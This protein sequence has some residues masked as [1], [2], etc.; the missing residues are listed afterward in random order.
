[1]PSRGHGWGHGFAS[2]P[3]GPAVRASAG[4][5]DHPTSTSRLLAPLRSSLRK[6]NL[7]VVRGGAPPE[8]SVGGPCRAAWRTRVGRGRARRR[9]WTARAWLPGRLPLAARLRLPRAEL[10]LAAHLRSWRRLAPRPPVHLARAGAGGLRLPPRLARRGP[11]RPLGAR[12]RHRPERMKNDG[13]LAALGRDPAVARLPRAGGG[14]PPG[15]RGRTKRRHTWTRSPFPAPPSSYRCGSSR[16]HSRS[17]P[18]CSAPAT[19]APTRARP[20]AQ[21]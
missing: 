19:S 20:A 21:R 6:N 1:M 17:A 18:R 8:C 7:A 12:G 15:S 10:D 11:Q 5:A 4:N 13:P 14:Y 3:D 2:L 16:C 9:A